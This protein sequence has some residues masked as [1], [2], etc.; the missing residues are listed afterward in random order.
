MTVT[1]T[2]AT[3]GRPGD[4]DE[5]EQALLERLAKREERRQRRMKEALDRQKETE[6]SQTSHYDP[7]ES[8]V[9]LRREPS[10][11]AEEEVNS[12]DAEKEEDIPREERE[13]VVVEKP[14]RSY[15]REQVRLCVFIRLI[16]AWC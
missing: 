4:E 8:G 2:A 16:N 10:Y 15:L 7:E 1:D 11:E 12:K 13:E 5:E 9:G 3:S 6:S 14:R